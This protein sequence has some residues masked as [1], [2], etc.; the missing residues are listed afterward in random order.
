MSVAR[1]GD[2]E[3]DDL[4]GFAEAHFVGEDAPADQR[5]RL[6]QSRGDME[7]TKINKMTP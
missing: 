7:E 6:R 1:A 2:E 3:G 5:R 4:H